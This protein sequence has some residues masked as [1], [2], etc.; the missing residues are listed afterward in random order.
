[1]GGFGSGRLRSSR[2]ANVENVLTI[3]I[4]LLRRSGRLEAG[5]SGSLQWVSGGQAVASIRLSAVAER[6]TLSYRIPISGQDWESTTAHIRMVRVPCHL[7]GARPYFICPATGCGRRVSKLHCAGRYF[8]CRHCSRLGY[9]SQ[10]EDAW[11]R[12]QRRV[13]KIK[14]RLGGEP[15]DEWFPP[16]PKHMWWRTYA[17]L[18]KSLSEAELAEEKA[19]LR[20]AEGASGV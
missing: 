2:I 6:L 9:T 20:L 1:M 5:W 18:C 11:Q 7:G 8:L 19:L 15:T 10:G 16:K 14:S 13:L 17:R 4:N 3:D 12:K